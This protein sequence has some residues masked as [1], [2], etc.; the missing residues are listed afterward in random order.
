MDQNNCLFHHT[1]HVLRHCNYGI[2]QWI[3]CL[4]GTFQLCADSISAAANTATGED[5]VGG[6]GKD[7]VDN[8]LQV[9]RHRTVA[10]RY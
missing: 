2:T 3:D 10:Q 4:L 7:R 1:H 8:T 5:G 6:R 9:L